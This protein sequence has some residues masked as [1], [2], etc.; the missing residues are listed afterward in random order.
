LCFCMLGGGG[1]RMWW[2]CGPCAWFL[3]LN[4]RV[5]HV[6][7]GYCSKLNKLMIVIRSSSKATASTIVLPWVGRCGDEA[8]SAGRGRWTFC[9]GAISVQ[10]LLFCSGVCSDTIV[11]C[12]HYPTRPSSK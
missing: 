8:E 7:A 1:V 10:R 11:T 4:F 6:C 9:D 3:G 5:T 12:Y 2:R